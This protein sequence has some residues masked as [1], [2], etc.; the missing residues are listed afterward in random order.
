MI[1]QF[2]IVDAKTFFKSQIFY[3]DVKKKIFK[4]IL[5]LTAGEPF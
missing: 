4:N 1:M 2:V 3:N 5:Y